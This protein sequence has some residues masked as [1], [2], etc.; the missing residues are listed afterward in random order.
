MRLTERINLV[1]E[2]PVDASPEYRVRFD[3][4]PE[5]FDLVQFVSS[6]SN[7]NKAQSLLKRVLGNDFR[8]KVGGSRASGSNNTSYAIIVFAIAKLSD[9][10]FSPIRQK[11]WAVI[12]RAA[13]K[14]VEGNAAGRYMV[15]IALAFDDFDIVIHLESRDPRKL[16][17]SL[18]SIEDLL[19]E[20]HGVILTEAY[21]F[22]STRTI[23]LRTTNGL[24][25]RCIFYSYSRAKSMF[26]HVDESERKA[27][28]EK[29]GNRP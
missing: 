18:G 22:A 8:I 25:W 6:L 14:I 21:L 12:N 7:A 19:R 16:A 9:Y 5:P 27:A 23:E 26:E 2:E 17:D 29:R 13:Q 3:D 28:H 15:E 4:P 20:L 11:T 24:N 10:V 1:V